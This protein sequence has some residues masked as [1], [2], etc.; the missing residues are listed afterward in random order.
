MHRSLIHMTIVLA[1][2]PPKRSSVL[3]TAPLRLAVFDCSVLTTDV[4]AATLMTL[5]DFG[6][7]CS[8]IFPTCGAGSV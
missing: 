8:L 4:I 6:Q 5:S 7:S 3:H 2:V 1:L